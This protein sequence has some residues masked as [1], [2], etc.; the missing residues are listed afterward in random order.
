SRL[1]MKWQEAIEKSLKN[2]K[3]SGKIRKEVNVLQAAW[4]VM[5][6]YSGVRNLGKIYGKDCYNVYLKE[7]KHYLKG[8]EPA[9]VS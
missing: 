9:P 5:S 4:F 2:G 8:L 3:T 1:A 7:L 6:G